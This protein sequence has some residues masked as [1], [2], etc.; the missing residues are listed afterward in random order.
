MVCWVDWREK[1]TCEG[2]RYVVLGLACF[3][4]RVDR[5]RG[6]EMGQV[7]DG[8]CSRRERLTQQDEADSQ[9][10]IAAGEYLSANLSS[11]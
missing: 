3:V 11:T 8:D 7:E 10:G 4:S 9:I 5:S 2:G 1:R 6:L